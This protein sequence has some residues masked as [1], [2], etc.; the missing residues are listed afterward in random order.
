MASNLGV[1]E[2]TVALFSCF[3]LD[4]DTIV[5]DVGHQIYAHK[6]LT[7]RYKDFS[8]LRTMGGISGFPSRDES[9]YDH[10][11][12]GHSS[13]SVSS[14]LGADWGRF[15]Q[16]KEG[17]T[18]AVIGDGS[19]TGGL[20][21]EGLNNA[22][23]IHRN[24]IVIV[25]DNGMS[26]SKNVGGLSKYLR[27]MRVT[28]KYIQAK[29]NTENIL[30]K[31]PVIGKPLAAIARHIKDRVKSGVI[32]STIFDDL[33]FEYYGPFDGNDLESVTQVLSVVKDLDKPVL[34]HLRTKKGKG[35]YYAET[36]PN[37]YHG[38]GGF[39]LASGKVEPS[40]TNF[41][42][43]FGNKLCELAEKDERICG[44]TAAMASGTGMVDFTK[45]FPGRF[46]DTGIAEGHAVTF[47][48]GLA[49][50]GMLPIFAVYS[51]FLQ[52][53][54]DNII[55]DISLQNFK[56]LIAVDRAG[57]VG[58]DGKTHNGVFDC[59]FLK[60]VPNI[61]VYSPS[62]YSELE[63]VMD[64]YLTDER[65]KLTVVRY[66]RGG[67]MFKPEDFNPSFGNYDVYGDKN[68]EITLVTY[69]RMFSQCC[70]A[71][72][73][74]ETQGINVKILKLNRIVPID[75]NSVKEVL[76]SKEIFFFEEGY[77]VGGIG[78]GFLSQLMINGFSGKAHLHAIDSG[79]VP[80]GNMMKVLEN[81]GLTGEKMAETV[82]TTI[83]KEK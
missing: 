9:P 8:G 22:G 48:G 20:A 44:I 81:L 75:V 39:D 3:D 17:H 49:E 74:L 76:S 37:V 24:F 70:L 47:S 68:A 30:D 64:K 82:K 43:V 56:A 55:H 19:L 71:K 67:E 72:K 66:P 12:T 50:K 2:L 36:Q 11:T 35:A 5:W 23:R 31:I 62:F 7:G 59:A 32:S 41:S 42:K 79:F 52:R 25:N 38:V 26:I 15:L 61:D 73:I 13:A 45:K 80:H 60:T 53:A 10:F 54:Y 69:G 40:G 83:D 65:Q 33:G 1:V 18:I 16:G 6:L 4:K 51:T 46:F 21:F 29:Q 14:A 63:N 78:E 77:T 28:Q 34:V 57:I 58:E 27:S